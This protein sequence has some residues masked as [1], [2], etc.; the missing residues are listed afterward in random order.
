MINTITCD[1]NTVEV[2]N[3]L[4]DLLSRPGLI[5]LNAQDV[6][7]ITKYAKSITNQT[8]TIKEAT[9][10]AVEKSGILSD[11][12]KRAH[13]YIICVTAG[14]N[15]SLGDLDTIVGTIYSVNDNERTFASLYDEYLT[16]EIVINT[17]LVRL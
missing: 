4:F 3:K 16:N 2:I 12:L 7:N 15:L 5:N 9:R 11:E 14:A 1:K 17:F 6:E 13:K 10:E 8:V